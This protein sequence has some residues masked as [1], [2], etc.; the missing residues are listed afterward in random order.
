MNK[1]LYSQINF[2][3]LQNRVY[4]TVEEAKNCPTGDIE[5]VQNDENSLIYNNAFDLN[6]IVYDKNYDNEQGNS[7]HFQNHLLEV[8]EMIEQNL[9]KE[10]LVEV[11]CGKGLFLEMLINRNFDIV[12]FDP[13]YVG[14]NPRVI[15]KFF[16]TGIISKPANGLILRHVLE[17]I[18]NPYIFLSQL[19]EANGVK[20]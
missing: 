11:G 15:K 19:K 6:I 16:E 12:G 4:E 5:I 3:V 1:I 10:K 17:H 8:A 18:L 7:K 9:G 2:P 13:T 14:N 20:D